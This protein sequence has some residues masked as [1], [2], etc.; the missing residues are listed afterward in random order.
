M[1]GISPQPFIDWNTAFG[2]QVDAGIE[3][4]LIL[5]GFNPQPE[6]PPGG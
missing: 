2:L 6:P 3:N 1:A 4:P 5:F